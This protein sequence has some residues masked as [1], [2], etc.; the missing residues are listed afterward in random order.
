MSADADRCFVC[1]A[2][3]LSYY[4]CLY[5]LHL[6]DNLPQFILCDPDSVIGL[7]HEY[8][9]TYIFYFNWR[10]TNIFIL[11]HTEVLIQVSSWATQ[12]SSVGYITH[13]IADDQAGNEL[14]HKSQLHVEKTRIVSHKAPDRHH[15]GNV[16]LRIPSDWSKFEG[17]IALARQIQ[18]TN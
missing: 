8:Y 11:K 2:S 14:T 6:H 5:E 10:V 13:Y 7:M 12:D 18:K 16:L 3:L 15:I 4:Q 9:Y 1:I 17:D